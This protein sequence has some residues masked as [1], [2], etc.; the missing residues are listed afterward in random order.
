MI[1]LRTSDLK[2]D[3]SNL[4]KKVFQGE[5]IVITRPRRENVVII[6]EERYNKLEELEKKAIYELKLKKGFEAVKE[7]KVIERDLIE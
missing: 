1:A 4:L 2:A 5:K 6:S 7:G 3:M